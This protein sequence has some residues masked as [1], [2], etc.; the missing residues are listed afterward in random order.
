M[1]LSLL[2]GPFFSI[3]AIAMMIG[4]VYTIIRLIVGEAVEHIKMKKGERYKR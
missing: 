2:K 3:L 1:D 4:T